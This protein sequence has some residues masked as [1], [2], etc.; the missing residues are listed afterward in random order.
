MN[1]L[2]RVWKPVAVAYSRYYPGIC[3]EVL[4]KE[5]A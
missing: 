3:V 4:R 1:E 2:E 5:T